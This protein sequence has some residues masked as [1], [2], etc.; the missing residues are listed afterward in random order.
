MLLLVSVSI[1]F[2]FPV[3]YDLKTQNFRDSAPLILNDQASVSSSRVPEFS[4][5]QYTSVKSSIFSSVLSIPLE[6]R[7]QIENTKTWLKK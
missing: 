5:V 6:I 2:Q 1:K 3:S 7:E 4:S